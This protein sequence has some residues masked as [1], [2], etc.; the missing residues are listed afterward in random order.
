MENL[1]Y[2]ARLG[3][4]TWSP[5]YVGYRE[6]ENPGFDK[7]SLRALEWIHEV[8]KEVGQGHEKMPT[9]ITAQPIV[10]LV[11]RKVRVV[12]VSRFWIELRL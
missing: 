2:L 5:P 6:D 10:V 3:W 1:G 7:N 9:V 8:I 11:G 12:F 4:G